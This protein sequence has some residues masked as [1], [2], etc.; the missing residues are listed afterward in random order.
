M[1][2]Y[3]S[4]RMRGLEPYT[5]GEQPQDKQ[6]IKLNTN[7]SPYGPSPKVKEALAAQSS[8]DMRLYPDPNGRRLKRAIAKGNGLLEEEIFIG[9]GSDEVLAFAFMTFADQQH[10]LAF[11]ETSYSFYPVWANVFEIPFRALPLKD[12]LYIDP[13]A[14]EGRKETIVLCNPNAPT[15][16]ALKAC[17]IEPLLRE[18][19]ERLVI[20]DEAYVD[21]GAES[22]VPYIHTYPNLLVVQ[23]F[24]KSRSLAGARLG[25]AMG[26]KALIDALRTMKNSFNSYTINRLTLAMGEAAMEDEAY[27]QQTRQRIMDTRAETAAALRQLGFEVAESRTNFLWVRHPERS[28]EALYRELK[29]RGILVRHFSAPELTE[30]L[31]ITIGSAE[32]MKTLVGVIGELVSKQ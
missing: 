28:G 15:S 16:T 21:F 26:Q 1:S 18:D 13:K 3:L 31:R 2:V 30:H 23:T 8:E 25:F 11:A 12:D 29:E 5:P 7:E 32:D 14:F 20:V 24:S 17:E 19:P 9:N 22:M 10:G 27:F 4:E 6:Y